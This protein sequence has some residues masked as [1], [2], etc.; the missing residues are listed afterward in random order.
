MQVRFDPAADRILWQ[1][2]TQGGDMFSAWL[3]RRMTRGFWPPFLN[4]VA[5]AGLPAAVA[6]APAASVMPEAR[7]MLADVARTRPLPGAAFNQPFNT[8]PVATPLGTEPLLPVAIDMGPGQGAPGVALRLRDAN[9]RSLSL[10]L[11]ADLAS[12]LLR[13]MERAITEADWGIAVPAAPAAAAA[14]APPAA[15]RVLN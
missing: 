15:P 12:A 11:N 13:L 6:A 1:L 7:E 8:Q 9:G 5:Q 3:T 4:L 10:Q 2:R 14:D